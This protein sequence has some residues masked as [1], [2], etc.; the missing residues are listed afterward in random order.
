M[1]D[2]RHR[3]ACLGEDPELFFP[4]G[5]SGPALL[6]IAGAKAVCARCPVAAECL[7]WALRSGQEAGVWGGLSEGERRAL[8]RNQAGGQ[9]PRV[10]EHEY[11]NG[12]RR[13]LRTNANTR[14]DGRTGGKICMD[15]DTDRA[16]AAA[17]RDAR[18]ARD[19]RDEA[20]QRAAAGM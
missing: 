15:C 2:W 10:V 11:C 7:A 9:P 14:I 17:R 4:V 19:A 13:H 6:Q 18:L 8:K 12:R 16:G 3:A 5:T 20:E 1:V